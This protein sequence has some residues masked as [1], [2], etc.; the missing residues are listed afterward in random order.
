MWVNERGDGINAC[1]DCGRK[2]RVDGGT[3]GSGLLYCEE[4]GVDGFDPKRK[5][6][7]VVTCE[8]TEADVR[9]R[10][11]RDGDDVRATARIKVSINDAMKARGLKP[12]STHRYESGTWLAS[13]QGDDSGRSWAQ[14]ERPTEVDALETLAN[15]LGVV[16]SRATKIDS[17]R[18]SAMR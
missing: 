7:V 10:V 6:N 16:L 13:V 12:M 18:S 8:M 17:R 11:E 2:G 14:A 5:T 4:H 3:Y 9:E 1:L 15:L